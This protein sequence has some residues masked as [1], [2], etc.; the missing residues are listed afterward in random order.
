MLKFILLTPFVE[1]SI[2]NN[3]F[4]SFMFC[5]C[6]YFLNTVEVILPGELQFNSKRK[7]QTRQYLLKNLCFFACSE[8]DVSEVG[9]NRPIHRN[10]DNWEQQEMVNYLIKNSCISEARG[11]RVWKQMID[12]GL[13]KHRTVHSLN[14]HFRRKILPNIHQFEMSKDSREEFDRLKK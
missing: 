13:L 4:L 3:N 14:N 6:E 7:E 11:N 8:T 12:E 2:R 5:E 1:K 10:F 9:P